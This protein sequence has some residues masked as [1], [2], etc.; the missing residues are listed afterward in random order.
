M[1]SFLPVL[2]ALALSCEVASAAA[3][4]PIPTLQ[5]SL[6]V[7][8][9]PNRGQAKPGILFLS[10]GTTPIAVTAG[11]ISYSP[12]GANLTLLASNPNPQ[13]SFSNPQPG[14]VNSYT[15]ADPQKWVTGIP[16]YAMA[17]LLAV[18]P[19]IDAQYTIGADGALTLNL[20]FQPGVDPKVVTF[21][22]PQAAALVQRSDGSLLVKFGPNP[23]YPLYYPAPLAFQTARSGSVN[24]SVNFV[25]QS[26]GFGLVVPG[27]DAT[28]PL[29][30]AI[31]VSGTSNPQSSFNGAPHTVDSNGNTFFARS[32]PDAAGKDGPFPPP[33]GEGCGVSMDSPYPCS[34]AAVYKFSATGVLDFI[35]YLAG[36]T[37]D[38]PGFVGLA[39]DGTLVVA[40]TTDSSDFPVSAAAF[41]PVYAGPPAAFNTG[42]PTSVRG[43]FFAAK[44][45]PS[46]GQLQSSTYLGGPNSDS[47]GTAALGPDGSLYFLPVWTGRPSDGMP[48]SST[49][50]R[51]ACEYTPCQNGY[52][53]R[54]S[55]SLDKLIFGT[56]LPGVAQSTA[57]LYSDGSV[58]Y[59]GWALPGFPTTPGAYQPQNAG[60]DDGIVARL[61]PSGTKLLFATYI[62]GPDTDWIYRMA[63]APDGSV[64]ALV[65]SFVQCCIDVHYQLV[66]LDANGSRLLAQL[67]MDVADMV[68]DQSGNL[69]AL[70]FPPVTVSPDAFL[71]NPCG[72]DAYVKLSPSGQQLFATYL[73][74]DSGGFDGT[75]AQGT[76]FLDFSVGRYQV[77]LNQNMGPYAGCVVDAASFGNPLT[78]SPGAIV[79]IFG[80]GLGPKQGVGFDLVNGQVPLSLGGTQVLVNGA[81]V[82]ILYS[83]YGQL[84]LILPF[85]LVAGSVPTVQV[86]TNATPANL[87]SASYVQPAGI[88]LFQIGNGAA[89]VNQDG[90][91]NSPQNPA[92]PGS[93][94]SLFGTGGGQTMPASIEGQVTPLGLRP[95]VNQPQVQI[96][97][98]GPALSVQYAGAAPGLVSGV[99]QINVTLP[100]PLPVAPGYPK[101][102]L[103]L[104]VTTTAGTSFVDVT[105]SVTGQ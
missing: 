61:D 60:N 92:P 58:Y 20:T 78:F 95:L 59:S 56:Y 99:V 69:I 104:R 66:H 97:G 91:L 40:G 81:P 10:S 96:A 2:L 7:G 39:S 17:T 25:L 42:G 98:L 71:A 76:P 89:A 85:S 12:L 72:N 31:N 68:V 38:L 101:G 16:R 47:M 15:G 105:I 88:T 75:D 22:I 44:L 64:W 49:A 33:A 77:V 26:T 83:S 87:L 103:P 70:A 100:N 73:G 65:T 30:I 90:T 4:V 79:T 63:V 48:V 94:I 93:I 23:F 41:Q 82:P 67:P 32:I 43:D 35:T 45:D 24:R 37:N 62:G 50:L 1:R 34:D 86:V 74:I 27:L 52:V 13:V 57:Q 11:S 14:L 29:Q 46:T 21:Q 3:V 8:L 80:S 28:L 19:G 51:S 55:P 102:T 18:Y 6:P 36:R 5:P 53:A 9:E 54:L 84:N